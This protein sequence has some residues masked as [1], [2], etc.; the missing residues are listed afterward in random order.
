MLVVDLRHLS[1]LKKPKSAIKRVASNHNYIL[2]MTGIRKYICKHQTFILCMV[3]HCSLDNSLVN[4]NPLSVNKWSLSIH[5]TH[6]L[7][8]SSRITFMSRKKNPKIII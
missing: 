4:L 8:P 3:T 6:I 1:S 5:V 7:L 2:L